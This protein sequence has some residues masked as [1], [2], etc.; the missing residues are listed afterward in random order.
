MFLKW[1]WLADTIG[2]LLVALLLTLEIV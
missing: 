2:I 1:H